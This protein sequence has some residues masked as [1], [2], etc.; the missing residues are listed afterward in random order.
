MGRMLKSLSTLQK[1]CFGSFFVLTVWAIDLLL[2][3]FVNAAGLGFGAIALIFLV[4]ILSVLSAVLYI[5][6]VVSLKRSA[7]KHPELSLVN[8]WGTIILAYML[9]VLFI[10]V[11]FV[12]SSY[13]GIYGV[14]TPYLDLIFMYADSLIRNL[15]PYDVDPAFVLGL[16]ALGT[17]LVALSSYV[18]YCERSVKNLTPK[19]L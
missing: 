5:I 3:T 18:F 12:L 16:A 7:S 4:I 6:C 10:V 9:G 8:L 15:V 13:F 19:G 14:W 11:S 2:F 1:V 17:Y